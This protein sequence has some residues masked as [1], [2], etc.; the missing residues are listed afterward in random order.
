[1]ATERKADV[2]AV[3][4]LTPDELAEVSG[5]GGKE[6]LI[7]AGVWLSDNVVK[8]VGQFS[9]VRFFENLLSGL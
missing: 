7:A 9:L 2:V 6:T 8:P 3:R 1:M 5:G 4:E